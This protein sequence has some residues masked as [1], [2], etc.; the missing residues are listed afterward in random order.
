MGSLL[1]IRLGLKG[2]VISTF[3]PTLCTGILFSIAVVTTSLVQ[4]GSAVA[5]IPSM[6]APDGG[7]GHDGLKTAAPDILGWSGKCDRD[8]DD[9]LRDEASDGAA[10]GALELAGGCEHTMPTPSP[11]MLDFPWS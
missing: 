2:P 6:S 4:H 3:R 8:E 10:V 9:D 11:N 1:A 7:A 5:D